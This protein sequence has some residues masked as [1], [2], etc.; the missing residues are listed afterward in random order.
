MI[1]RIEGRLPELEHNRLVQ[2]LLLLA[3]TLVAAALRFYKLGAWSF[4]IDELYTIGR[5]QA[6]YSSL[7]SALRNI[8]PHVNWVPTSLL[9]SA[10]AIRDLGVSEW[11]ARLVPALIGVVSIPVLYLPTRRILGVGVALV[12]AL[13]L[14]ISP[15][16]LFWSQNARFYTALMLF[17]ML[18]L[19]AVYVG[20][21]KDRP[22]YLLV[23]LVFVYLAAS[24]RLF[25]ILLI[26]IVAIYLLLLWLLPLEKPAGLNRRNL[27][28]LA[29]P[30][31]AGLLIEGSTLLFTGNSRFFADLGWFFLY[32]NTSPFRLLGVFS[33]QVGFPLIALALFGGLYL[34]LQKSRI[35]LLLLL[36]AVV[37]V[38]SLLPLTLVMFTQERYAFLTL[39][40]WII[41]AAVTV[42]A[43]YSR[44]QSHQLLL[45]LALLALLVADA[46]EDTLLYY[47]ANEGNRR[48][49][50]TAFNVVREGA[51]E[52]DLVVAFWPEFAPYYLGRDIIAWD[53][54][55]VDDIQAS[56]Q[57]V[58]FVVDSE[59]VWGAP[60]KKTWIEANAE[61]IDVLYV[62]TPEDQNIRVYLYDPGPGSVTNR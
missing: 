49:W 1:D 19:L 31:V 22:A 61:L 16:H 12:A 59:T 8:P 30:V 11:S 46:T 23:A 20:L 7:E 40:A 45:A 17:S 57:R 26:P 54:I 29:S 34:F 60:Q 9:I 28:I 36:A 55:A 21:E 51:R 58:W 6:H 43:I 27:L 13:L 52:D 3:I 35:G 50:R 53:D 39:P 15:W 47:R 42:V 18:A 10:L 24:E 44:L 48:D 37:P 33:Y 38:I 56:Q 41:L 62:R 2:L 32:R 25:A 5:I 4:W 14:A